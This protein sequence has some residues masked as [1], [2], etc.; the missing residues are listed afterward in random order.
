[1]TAL[2]AAGEQSPATR[3]DWVVA[4]VASE[5]AARLHANPTFIRLL[6]AIAAVIQL[7]PVCALYGAAALVLPHEG[8]R[9]PGWSNLTGVLSLLSLVGVA[10]IGLGQVGLHSGFFNQPPPLWIA[11]GGAEL[12]LWLAVLDARRPAHGAQARD[13]R[14][15]ALSAVLPLTAALALAAVAE[16]APHAPIAVLLDV[17]LIGL[18][19]VSLVG[20]SRLN[21]RAFMGACLPLGLLA[22]ACAGS[23]TELNGGFGN[24]TAS[25]TTARAA[26]GYTRT[27]GLV[28]LDLSGLRPLPGGA[29][30]RWSAS[31]GAG[32]VQ[33][34]VP[35]DALSTVHVKIGSGSL[36]W[37]YLRFGNEHGFMVS[38]TVR[39]T[40]RQASGR[41]DAACAAAAHH[42]RHGRQGLCRD[43]V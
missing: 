30:S 5:L 22:L 6:I 33:I 42:L 17:A 31:V 9:R 32:T 26:H 8:G 24:L 2:T 23:G 12:L 15:L 29:S 21:R 28:R 36:N 19:G 11:E 18:G 41:H 25:P 43:R 1:M 13:D 14:R 37:A 3:S 38:R 10:A 39:I 40:P 4:G 20:G 34:D 27:A 16:L 7:W 35:S